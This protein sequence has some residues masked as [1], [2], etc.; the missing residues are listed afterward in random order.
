MLSGFERG[1]EGSG[2]A[3]REVLGPSNV[4]TCMQDNSQPYFLRGSWVSQSHPTDR[5]NSLE[6][7]KKGP[8]FGDKLEHIICRICGVPVMLHCIE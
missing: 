2:G 5:P 6:T 8:G 4:H 7:S 3:L 1:L